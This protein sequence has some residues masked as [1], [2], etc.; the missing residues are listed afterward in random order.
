MTERVVQFTLCIE[1]DS[2]ADAEELAM[3]VV[4]LRGLLLELDIE[5][6]DPL[7]RGPAPPGTRAGEMLVA[8]ALTVLLTRSKELVAKL[9]ESVQWWASLGAGRSVRLELDGDV[10]EVKG[11]TREDQGK[12]IQ[13]FID[14]HIDE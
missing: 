11:L 10:L 4:D 5:S 8:G 2:E 12:L 3:L 7:T 1:T 9:I 6:A 13:L 14:R